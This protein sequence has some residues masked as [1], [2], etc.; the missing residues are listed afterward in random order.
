MSYNIDNVE[1]RI[2]L[3]W[4]GENKM[5]DTR[6]Y[7]LKEFTRVCECNVVLVTIQNLNE[8]IL[9][10]APLHPAYQYLSET[11]KADYLRTYFMNF[12]G[13]GYSDVKIT[14][15][16]WVKCFDELNASDKWINGYEENDVAYEPLRAFQHELVGNCSY[17]CKKNTPLTEEWYNGMI[18]L[19]DTK[20][21]RLKM[22]P[23]TFLQDCA[24]VSNGRY[25]IEWN[26]MLG[27]IFSRIL[28]KYKDKIII[29]LPIP[30]CQNYR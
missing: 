7:C 1:N 23:S 21:E 16:S 9:P 24:E 5:S 6:E 26:E 30:I 18:S 4:T 2:F 13:G 17:I 11:H 29:A 12:Y 14:T 15:G 27:R 3:F 28:W 8:Y 10:S 19:L 20:L 22:Y 25:P